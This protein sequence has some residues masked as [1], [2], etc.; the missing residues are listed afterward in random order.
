MRKITFS[1]NYIEQ[2]SV[3]KNLHEVH[4]Q[5]IEFLKKQLNDKDIII[6]DL[7]NYIHKSDRKSDKNNK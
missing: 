1:E 6:N 2:I 3:L 7:K 5:E 4:I